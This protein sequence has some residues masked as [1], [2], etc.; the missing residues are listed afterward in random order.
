MDKGTGIVYGIATACGVAWLWSS[1]NLGEAVVAALA[2]FGLLVIAWH[3]IDTLDSAARNH[4][5]PKK[6]GK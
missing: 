5:A 6:E 1:L 3:A 4:Y 2:A